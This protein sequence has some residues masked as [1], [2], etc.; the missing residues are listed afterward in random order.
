MTREKFTVS[1]MSCA[2]CQANVTKA[3][4][5][6]DGVDSVNVNLITGMMNVDYDESKT[7]NDSIINAV[8]AIGY[9]AETHSGEKGKDALKN[10]WNSRRSSADEDRNK[11]KKRLIASI[12]LLIPLMYISMGGMMGLPLPPFFK[13]VSNALILSFTQLLITIP[14]LILNKKFFTSGLKALK[15]RVPNMDSLVALGSG[16]AFVYGIFAIYRMM[17]GFAVQ[18]MELVHQSDH[19]LY[20]ESSAMILT[21]VTV[22]KYLETKSKSK[23][24]ETLEKLVSLAPKTAVVLR[25]GKEITVSTENIVKGD[26]IIIKPG[27]SIPVD[28]TVISGSG[29]VDQS[30]ITGESI[31]V[32]K[33]EGDTVISATINKNGSF[34]FRAEKIGQDTTLS[35]II[36]M[37][38]DA[39]NTKAPIARLADKISGIFVPI[40]IGIA[41]ITAIIW[42]IWGNGFEFALNR[43]ISV[44]VISCPCALGLATPVAIMVGTGKAAEL[45]I[46]I[47]SAESLENLHKID[48]VVLDKTGTVTKGTPEVTD[49][50]PIGIS[51]DELIKFAA[52]AEKNSEHP[53]AQAVCQAAQSRNIAPL[54]VQNFEAVPG[55]GIKAT[56][57]NVVYYAGNSA[58]MDENG[59]DPSFKEKSKEF[60]SAGKTPLVFARENNVIGII[61]VAD[62]VRETSREAILDLKKE[63]IDVVLLT[64]DNSLSAQAIAKQVGIENVISDVLPAEKEAKIRELQSKGRNVAMVGDGINDSPALMRADIGIAIGAGTDIAIDCADIVLVKNSLSDAVNAIKLSKSVIRN[65]K[66]NLFWAFFYNAVGIPIAAGLLYPAFGI[67]LSPMI[68]SLAMS[69]SSLCVVT[70]A[71]RLRRFKPEKS[72]ENTEIKEINFTYKGDNTMTKVLTV[73]GMMCEH[74]KARVE[75]ALSEVDG[76]TSASVDLEKKTATAALSKEIADDV[77]IK[78]VTDAGYDVKGIE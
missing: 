42:I 50:Y 56:I 24:N 31:P 5:K 35:Q 1:G 58:F 25:D 73:E 7:D 38:D 72:T 63:N 64:G 9:G 18:D 41:L 49:V 69:L 16:A 70:N 48:T 11:T 59:I 57:D 17:Y 45:G 26:I 40:V 10:D 60:A 75:K 32:E 43:A 66:M 54:E 34:R 76:V 74:C 4:S 2:A 20:F 12:V 68:G 23:T 67:V 39:G 28:G 21:L 51:E 37:V 46:L 71:L 19:S 27:E 3:V 14:V 53:L 22:G 78:A 65:I 55:R 13:G 47:K 52:S 61:A 77:L 44:L 6:L 30:A 15:N 36:R 62:T 29:Y 33:L 8:T